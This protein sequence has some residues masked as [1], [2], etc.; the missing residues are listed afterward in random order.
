[1]LG[2]RYIDFICIAAGLTAVIIAV[3]LMFGEDMGIKRTS[4]Q[5][6]YAEKLFDESRVHDIE[7]TMDDFGAFLEDAGEEQY[8]RCDISIDGELVREAGIRVKGNNSR[9]LLEKYGHDRYSLKVEFDHYAEGN[10]YHGLDKMSLDASFQDNSYLKN[11]IAYDM[12]RYMDVPAPLCSYTW[13]EINGEPWGLFLAVEEPE[14]AFADR[15]Y[16][17]DHGMLYKPDYRRLEDEN[18]DVALI[19]TGDD[20]EDYENIFRNSSFETTHSDRKRLIGALERLNSGDD[21]EEAVDT[22]E[23]LRYFTVQTFVVNLDS[24]LG[25]TGHNYYLY[26]ED[27][28][29]SMLPWDYNLAFA[30][31]P[32]G[33]PEPVNDAQRYVNHPIDTPAE[34]EVMMGRPL[35]HELMK[36]D[37]YYQRYHGYYDELI[38]GYFESGHFREKIAMISEMIAPYVM[39][40]PTAFCSYEDHRK[41]VGTI[42]DFCML[43]AESVRRQLDGD[44][45]STIRGQSQDNSGFVDASGIWIPDMGEISDLTD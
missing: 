39:D 8:V 3:L 21:P 22:D 32:L 4:S 6:E 19:Y 40:D 29:I 43:R 5:P 10:L 24:Y 9:S 41:A 27:G 45:P 13:V 26:E 2:S 23:V 17:R 16:G 20:E 14:D 34:G 42:M 18:N 28:R 12:M 31:Y 30:T 38:S 36:R 25:P 7:I 44:I 37:V 33:M 11:Y 35:F 15:V 1:M